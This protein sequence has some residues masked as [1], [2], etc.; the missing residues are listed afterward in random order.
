MISLIACWSWPK[1]KRLK[2]IGC[3]FSAILPSFSLKSG[4]FLKFPQLPCFI[5]KISFS[6]FLLILSNHFPLK[7][8]EGVKKFKSGWGKPFLLS[9]GRKNSRR[10]NRGDRNDPQRI[11]YLPRRDAGSLEQNHVDRASCKSL[12]KA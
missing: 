11:P 5:L 7:S 8:T 3:L 9:R 1:M 10:Q 4:T 2:P 12:R 6:I